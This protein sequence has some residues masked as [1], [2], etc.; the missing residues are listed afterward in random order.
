MRIGRMNSHQNYFN[1]KLHRFESID[2]CQ[3]QC[4]GGFTNNGGWTTESP[5]GCMSN[6]VNKTCGTACEPTCGR[7]M[8]MACVASCVQGCQ[9]IDGYMRQSTSANNAFGRA[10]CVRADQCD[11]LVTAT[12][13]SVN[14]GGGSP[15]ISSPPPPRSCAANEQLNS[16][17]NLCEITCVNYRQQ[18][19]ACPM[20]CG[21]PACVCA[22]GYVR[23]T[24]RSGQCVQPQTCTS[25]FGGNGAC[26]WQ[27]EVVT[28]A[29]V[30]IF[31]QSTPRPH[32]SSVAQMN[33]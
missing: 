18:P 8:N 4:G 16:C 14:I 24:Q 13:S 23:D 27:I 5:N 12:T 31:I 30:S 6:E 22:N 2:D 32:L 28:I 1:F 15:W 9:C 11:V 25:S 21:T 3:R 29:E 26:E 7:P 19:L 20:I 17:G 10:P 33:S